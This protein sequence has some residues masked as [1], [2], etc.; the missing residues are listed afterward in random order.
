VISGT[1]RR[2]EGAAATELGYIFT[3]MLGV[4]LLSMFSIWAWDIETTTRERWNEEAL[5]D[6]MDR[7]ASAVERADR[8]SRS[9]DK[10]SYA[11]AVHL[12]AFEASK[13]S[14][15]ISLGERDL[16]L[17]DS[18]D[19]YDRSVQLSGS[20]LSTHQGEID[21]QGVDTI[22]AIHSDGVTK[23]TTIHPDW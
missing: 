17:H 3:F 10:C 2:D 11:E 23:I 13:A 1:L 9:A 19:I 20:G 21:L 8:A 12:T 18:A 16:V 14:L 4:V 22:W 5:Q 7:L 15:T 6:N